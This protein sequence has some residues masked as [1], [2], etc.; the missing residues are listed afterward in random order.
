MNA[1]PLSSPPQALLL[2]LRSTHSPRRPPPLRHQAGRQGF[3]KGD[4]LSGMRT[5]HPP[6][7]E[8]TQRKAWAAEAG[9]LGLSE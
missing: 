5:A 7:A 3:Q 2:H 9:A 1:N 4:L 8:S 6:S